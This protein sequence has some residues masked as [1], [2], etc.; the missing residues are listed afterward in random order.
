MPEITI[1]LC[2]RRIPLSVPGL[3][4]AGSKHEDCWRE[5]YTHKGLNYEELTT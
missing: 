1:K 4:Q 2:P 3:W 5:G